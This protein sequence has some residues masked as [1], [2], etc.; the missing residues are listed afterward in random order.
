MTNESKRPSGYELAKQRTEAARRTAAIEAECHE[1]GVLLAVAAM[2]AKGT[3]KQRELDPDVIEAK[4]RLTKALNER[5]SES[6]VGSSS[7]A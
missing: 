2:K 1:A 5:D 4:V 7:C 6:V 3:A